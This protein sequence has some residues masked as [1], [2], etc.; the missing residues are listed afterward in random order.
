[1]PGQAHSRAP[2]LPKHS[3]QRVWHP[4]QRC[5]R[6]RH[7]RTACKPV[8]AAGY[9]GS[10]APLHSAP[11]PPRS[12]AARTA[13]PTSWNA[14]QRR[15]AH[16]ALI[17][18]ASRLNQSG[19]TATL[20]TLCWGMHLTIIVGPEVQLCTGFRGARAWPPRPPPPLPIMILGLSMPCATAYFHLQ[21]C[22][23]SAYMHATAVAQTCQ[24]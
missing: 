9:A 5:H 18:A 19:G 20:S 8:P 4:P 15:L 2:K 24:G 6:G 22:A 10:R 3:M 7:R 12:P 16:V 17:N 1:M 23:R 21:T 14:M 11:R 13:A